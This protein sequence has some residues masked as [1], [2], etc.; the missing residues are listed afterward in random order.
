MTIRDAI[1]Q[2]LTGETANQPATHDPA[3]V[4]ADNGYG[5]VPS[6]LFGTALVHFSDT[7]PLAQA[8]ALAPVV[9]RVSPIP[10]E[11][12]DLAPLNDENLESSVD[13]SDPFALFV[14][15]APALTELDDFDDPVGVDSAEG[16]EESVSD[17]EEPGGDRADD[18]TDDALSDTDV[19]MDDEGG[20]ADF[21]SGTANLD[22]TDDV[23]PESPT[24]EDETYSNDDAML[25]DLAPRFDASSLPTETQDTIEEAGV[26][27]FSVEF[28]ETDEAD[29][30]IDPDDLDFSD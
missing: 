15:A 17:S 6:E 21:G 18:S 20:D 7:A 14:A 2:L 25:D 19:L 1:D 29:G 12:T 24:E 11:D 4:M 26:D 9:T 30:G 10:F 23:D 28:D 5:D 22:L 27:L 13:G 3:T 16:D 8:D